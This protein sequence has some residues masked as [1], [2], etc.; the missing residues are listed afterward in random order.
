MKASAQN[1][2]ESLK[3][4]LLAAAIFLTCMAGGFYLLPTAEDYTQPRLIEI[5]PASMA[6]T[7]DQGIITLNGDASISIDTDTK[8]NDIKDKIT[9]QYKMELSFE[10]QSGV[11]KTDLALHIN[12]K[13]KTLRLV[14]SGLDPFTPVRL[15]ERGRN[16][17]QILEDLRADWSGRIT[18]DAPLSDT[19]QKY[20]IQG[21]A[22]IDL[23]HPVLRRERNLS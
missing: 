2:M 8:P 7:F 6:S 14:L 17:S 5:Y 1:D 18:L 13:T 9:D 21:L 4:K 12:H 16:A 23:C 11:R 3:F 22:G 10:P 19:A 15:E 20:C